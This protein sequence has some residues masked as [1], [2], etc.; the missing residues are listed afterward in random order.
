MLT[1]IFHEDAPRYGSRSGKARLSRAAAE[2]LRMV[3]AI[4]WTCW[5]GSACAADTGPDHVSITWMSVTNVHYELGPLHIL[6]ER[7]R[8]ACPRTAAK[9]SSV[10]RRCSWRTG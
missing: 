10:A 1:R 5:I 4:S 7:S 9:R 6:A 3:V 2:I 8:R